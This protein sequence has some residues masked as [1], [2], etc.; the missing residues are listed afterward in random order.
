MTMSGEP[1]DLNIGFDG[2]TI[3][4]KLLDNRLTSCHIVQM[5]DLGPMDDIVNNVSTSN[6]LGNNADFGSIGEMRNNGRPT[7][8]A[9]DEHPAL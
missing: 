9:H 6:F 7:Q 3:D 2:A 1:P 4:P 5:P 8:L